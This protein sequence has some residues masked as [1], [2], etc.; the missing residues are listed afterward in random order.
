MRTC[1]PIIRVSVVLKGLVREMRLILTF[2]QMKLCMLD[3]R[4]R[5]FPPK[6]KLEIFLTN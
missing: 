5:S 6:T 2:A 1:G 3:K 4:Q